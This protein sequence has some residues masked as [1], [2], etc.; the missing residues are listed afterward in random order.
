MKVLHL[1]GGRLDRGAARGAYWLHRALLDLGVESAVLTNAR[2]TLGDDTVTT[3]VDSLLSRARLGVRYK[4]SRLPILAYPRRQATAFSTGLDGIDVTRYP[5]YQAAD[6]IHMHWINSLVSVRSLKKV[7]KPLV[8][9]LRDMWPMTGGCH[10][11]LDCDRFMDACGACPQLGATSERDL[12]QFVLRHKRA[13]VPGHTRVVG[14]SDWIS[15]RARRSALF[16]DSAVSTIS[17]NVDTETFSPVDKH[18]ARGALGLDIERR[19]LLVGALDITSVYKGFDL[20]LDALSR[21]PKDEIQVVTFGNSSDAIPVSLG[22]TVT[23]LGMLADNEILRR[24]YSAADVF[25]APSRAESFGKTLAE[26]MACGTP[27]V[28]FDATGPRDIVD[29]RKTGY[30][31]TAFDPADLAHGIEWVLGHSPNA[32]AELCRNA[33]ERATSHFDSR[34]IAGQYSRLYRELLDTRGVAGTARVA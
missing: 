3:V 33:R 12:S 15:E 19:V 32:Y 20:L 28:C 1:V 16:R 21:L 23:S 10:H 30:K 31:A 18:A 22:L 6:L 13:A 34:V 24:A 27:V 14:M 5:A 11:A 29:H 4:A 2:D 17:N 9:T 8:W 25:V 26:A 7:T